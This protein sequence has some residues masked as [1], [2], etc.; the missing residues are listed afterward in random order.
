[1]MYHLLWTN[2]FKLIYVFKL[3]VHVEI[4]QVPLQ[5]PWIMKI[6]HGLYYTDGKLSILH[7]LVCPILVCSQILHILQSDKTW[8]SRH[9]PSLIAV[10]TPFSENVPV[11]A[12]NHQPTLHNFRENQ[13]LIIMCWGT[14]LNCS[15]CHVFIGNIF[16]ST[17]E[18]LITGLVAR[19]TFIKHIQTTCNVLDPFKSFSYF[20]KCNCSYVTII[21][22]TF[23]TF[24][25]FLWVFWCIIFFITAFSTNNVDF[26]S[27]T[28]VT[29]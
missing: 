8:T 20:T 7:I 10:T 18:F 22:S 14:N 5:L 1:M 2:W 12:M 25:L 13:W 4:F 17:E 15:F 23:L 29:W 24:L 16:I 6:F 9:F 26:M 11:F 27:I 21:F 28:H 19:V 3:S